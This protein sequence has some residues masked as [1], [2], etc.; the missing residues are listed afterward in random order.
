MSEIV[1]NLG[2][3]AVFC[4]FHDL[5]VPVPIQ[6]PQ[7]NSAS[8][9]MYAQLTR[10]SAAVKTTVTANKYECILDQELG[11]AAAYA[12]G[13]RCVCTHQVAALFCVK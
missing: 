2:D 12:P 7:R 5:H 9:R 6:L 11:D 10:C 1:Y 8:A 13:R 4:A 3:S